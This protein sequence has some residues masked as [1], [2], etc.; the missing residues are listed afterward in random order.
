[1]KFGLGRAQ[2]WG[3]LGNRPGRVEGMEAGRCGDVCVANRPGRAG[4]S[5]SYLHVRVEKIGKGGRARPSVELMG[6]AGN[7]QGRP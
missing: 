2:K 1:M 6:A 3:E 7:E 5:R 4:A